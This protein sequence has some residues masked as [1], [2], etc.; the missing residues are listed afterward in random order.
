MPKPYKTPD[1][2]QGQEKE[3][4][5]RKTVGV[6]GRPERTGPSRGIML[7]IAA[8]LAILVIFM[9]YR[10]ARGEELYL[11]RAQSHAA[12]IYTSDA[13]LNL[14]FLMASNV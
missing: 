8:I 1:P 3:S 7:A 10:L 12:S 6:Y 4:S 14:D 5:P 2:K 11:A 9:L 13:H